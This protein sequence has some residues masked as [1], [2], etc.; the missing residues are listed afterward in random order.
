MQTVSSLMCFKCDKV[1][2]NNKCYA[3]QNCAETDRYCVTK[4]FG[5]GRGE[6][7]TQLISKECS[8]YCP[9]VG[10]DIGVMAFSINCCEHSLCNTSGAVSVKTSSLLLLVGT[11]ASVFYIIG[12]HL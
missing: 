5:G 11:L 9:E 8:S 10:V 1:D 6:S 12:A 4:Y 2:S 7:Y 3:V